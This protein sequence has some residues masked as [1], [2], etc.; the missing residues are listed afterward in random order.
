METNLT[1]APEDRWWRLDQADQEPV[2][3]VHDL[4]LSGAAAGGHPMGGRDTAEER[5]PLMSTLAENSESQGEEC[6]GWTG[7]PCHPTAPDLCDAAEAHLREAMGEEGD[8]LCSPTGHPQGRPSDQFVMTAQIEELVERVLTYLGAGFAV[9]L[10]GLPG[11]GK[12]ALAFHL[13]ERLARP[14]TLVHGDDE[15][16][17]SDLVGSNQGFRTTKLVDTFVHTVLKA[18]QTVKTFWVDNRLTTAVRE[19]HTL[20]YDEFTRSRPEA[21][22]VLLSILGEGLL[23]LPKP[24]YDGQGC[25]KAHPD[26]RAIFTCNPQEYA[27]VHRGQDALL[28]RL[29]AIRMDD[30]DRE[31]EV[32]I[33]VAKS[34]VSREEAGR[35]VDVVRYFRSLAGYNHRPSVRAAI[36]I[37]KVTAYRGGKCDPDDPRFQQ[38]CRDALGLEGPRKQTG[39]KPFSEEAIQEGIHQAWRLGEV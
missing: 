8:E 34:G 37:A 16:G 30:Y 23:N 10:E 17:S 21:N 3:G 32:A 38:T 2:R 35:I 7:H 9:N 11:S 22:N 19:G 31:T 29:I 5:N 28:D 36:M 1:T 25:L 15:L 13:A 24:R 27:G 20:I 39:G 33:T 6:Q 18:E 14:V 26:F 12:T 4:S